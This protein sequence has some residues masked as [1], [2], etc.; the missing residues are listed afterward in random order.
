MNLLYELYR[1]S[2][3]AYS[4]RRYVTALAAV[5]AGTAASAGAVAALLL[6]PVGGLALGLMAGLLAFAGLLLYP[7]HLVSARRSHFENNFVYTLGVLLPL[8][9][10]GVPLGR[11]VTRLAEVEEDKYIARELALAAREMIVMGASQ[12]EALA[13]SAERVPSVTYRETVEVLIRSAKI[14]QRVDAVLL[15]RLD[16][17]LRNKQ[18]RAQSLI[19]SLSLMFEIFVVAAMLLPLMVYIVALSFSPLGA[20]EVGGLALD[21]L[22]LMLLLGVVYTPI[23]GTVF[24]I[25]FDSM[26]QI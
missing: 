4:Y 17:L 9:A 20:L 18:V 24:Y 15:A 8:L 22:T 11:A 23:V 13:H 21:P 25:I 5:P 2:G 19:R 10:A 14:T 3:L 16:W 26:V 6:G 12:E 7:V 1:Q